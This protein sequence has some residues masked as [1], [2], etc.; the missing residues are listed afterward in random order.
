MPV[1]QN[2]HEASTGGKQNDNKQTG[3]DI[4]GIFTKNILGRSSHS[5]E[6]ELKHT[7]P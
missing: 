3:A 5:R 1:Q 2:M 4:L 7:W 6:D